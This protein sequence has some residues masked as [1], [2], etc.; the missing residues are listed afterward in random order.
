MLVILALYVVLVTVICSALLW[1][2]RALNP[3]FLFVV[4]S[5]V[6]SM[7][8]I[9]NLDAW[10]E[11]D[12]AHVYLIILF[13]TS[14]FLHVVFFHSRKRDSMITAAWNAKR[15]AP[16]GKEKFG[17]LL[18]IYIFSAAVIIY[19]F[20]VLVG[21]NLF[22]GAVFGG[23]GDFTS[24][25]LA[26][27][28]GAIYTGAGVVNQFKNTI[29]PI[30]FF[31][32]AV[33]LFYRLQFIIYWII[34]APASIFYLWSILGTGQRTH[35]F[36]SMLC[37]LFYFFNVGKLSIR[38]LVPTTTVFLVLFSLFSLSLGRTDN[39]S[40]GKTLSQLGSRLFVE[41]QVGTVAGMR[42]VY[43]IP[44]QNGSEWL[45]IL[46]GYVQIRSRL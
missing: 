44:I 33:S 27:Y 24:L 34:A 11:S 28:S 18:F 43:D 29:F 9:A 8:A 42:Y 4:F 32:L 23:I 15:Y 38:V 5:G 36:F 7:G 35:F 30:A 2:N 22:A 46:V 1:R 20:E 40:V 45:K 37:L 10:V 21:Y 31:V 39:I 26:S 17:N 19:Y 3:M 13:F 6:S 12:V 14:I 16:A 41:N 25:R